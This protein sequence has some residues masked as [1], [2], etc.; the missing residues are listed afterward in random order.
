MPHRLL[1]VVAAFDQRLRIPFAALGAE[2]VAAV[3]V[4]RAGEARDRVGDRMDDVL[5]ER[6]RVALAQRLCPRRLDFASGSFPEDIVFAAGVYTPIT[7]H[8]RWLCG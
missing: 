3:D 5:P 2:E 1:R 8:M 7:A 4:E 6:Y